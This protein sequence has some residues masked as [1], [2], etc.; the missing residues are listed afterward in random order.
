[1]PSTATLKR[2]FRHAALKTFALVAVLATTTT[3]SRCGDPGPIRIGVCIPKDEAIDYLAD[4]AM[5]GAYARVRMINAGGGVN[6]RRLELRIE[7]PD[8][9]ES[10]VRKTIQK[11]VAVQGVNAILVMAPTSAAADLVASAIQSLNEPDGGALCVFPLS[12]NPMI[13][14]LGPLFIRILPDYVYQ[15]TVMSDYLVKTGRRRLSILYDSRFPAYVDMARSLALHFGEAGGAVTA[16]PYEIGVATGDEDFRP[17]LRDVARENPDVIAVLGY[18]EEG[19]LIVRQ[20]GQLGI[21]ARLCGATSWDSQVML[22]ASGAN[23]DQCFFLSTTLTDEND[24]LNQVF[25]EAVA[26]AGAEYPGFEIA[27]LFD[28]IGYLAKAFEKADSPAGLR[29]ELTRIGGEFPAVTGKLTIEEGTNR[30]FRDM[31]VIGIA[32]DG[33]HFARVLLEHVPASSWRPELHS[34]HD[35]ENHPIEKHFPASGKR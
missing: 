27:V 29:E 23:L 5:I 10:D 9:N 13:E 11:M 35:H 34:G 25:V 30:I 6:G 32:V 20:A 4:S 17:I 26:E 24:E 3:A 21:K 31:N 7:K 8:N 1:M 22:T 28:T 14:R 2:L 18:P 15:S 19:A 12:L 33:R 16:H